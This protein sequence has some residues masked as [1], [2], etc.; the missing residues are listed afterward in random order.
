MTKLTDRAIKNAKAST[1]IK[2]LSDGD[3][4]V[5]A[6]HPNGSKYWIYRYRHL[7]KEKTLSLG[8]YPEVTLADA[9]QK[10]MD[11]RKL[12]SQ[13]VDP[14]ETRKESKR[15]ALVS[16][17]NTF[18]AI[19]RE[20]VEAKSAGWTPR[21]AEFIVQRMEIDLF[22]QLGP[23]PI[24]DITAPEVLSVVRLIEKRGALDLANR[25]LQYCGQIFMFGIATGRAER[26]PASDLKGAQDARQ[27]ALCPPQSR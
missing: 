8:V 18:E 4:P 1:K 20:W 23:R 25:A 10:L 14:S 9:R 16:A 15:H 21:Y 13:G 7:G 11:A 27:E 12:Q 26:N 5:L 19:A 22:P 17:A 24:K 3:G 6:V 2:K